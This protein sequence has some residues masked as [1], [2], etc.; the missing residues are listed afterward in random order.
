MATKRIPE[1]AALHTLSSAS[2]EPIAKVVG[3]TA[4][5]QELLSIGVSIGSILGPFFI[6]SG[7]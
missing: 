1:N 2:I 4:T 5:L 3:K 7:R 6:F